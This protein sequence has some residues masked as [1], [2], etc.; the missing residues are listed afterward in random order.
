M[1]SLKLILVSLLVGGLAAVLVMTFVIPA[2][3]EH[4]VR[5]RLDESGFPDARLGVGHVG[6]DRVELLDVTLAPGIALGD[7]ELRPGPLALWRGEQA[8]A[9]L[10]RPR[11]DADA[12]AALPSRA[13]GS[14]LARVEIVDGELAHGDDRIAIRGTI[15]LREKR[16]RVALS[17]EA[18]RLHVGTWVA[19]DVAG[20]IRGSVGDLQICGTGSIEHLEI[21]A[22]ATVDAARARGVVRVA[23][24]ASIAGATLSD[25]TV[26]ADID[27]DL[28]TRAFFVTNGIATAR[29]VQL[30]RV[31]L[32]E[33]ELPFSFSG[34]IGDSLRLAADRGLV[35]SS[36]AATVALGGAAI[37]IERPVIAASGVVEL[38]PVDLHLGPREEPLEITAVVHGVSLDAITSAA[39][40]KR[41]RGTGFVD[42]TVVLAATEHGI[43]LR[44][45]ELATTASGTLRVADA[46]KLAADMDRPFAVHA[47]IGAALA[48]FAYSKI[49]LRL[50]HE[51]DMLLSIHG[52][53]RRVPQEIQ[54]DVNVR[55]LL[56]QNEGS[57]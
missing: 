10:F 31:S 1:R 37:P 55:G 46:S 8:S 56:A 25:A 49:G 38:G 18:P 2:L 11:I 26:R 19:T 51:P 39:T 16:P 13:H 14:S 30:D 17:I 7:V 45:G 44:G 33:V 32:R 42:G 52:R 47:R 28:A 48:D 24:P 6:L 41:V 29:S 3:V 40:Q 53:G 15:D 22:C 43:R 27:V 23:L 36:R 9:I 21:D 20:T 50:D 35:L 54:I 57:P 5:T 34:S 4:G 12:L